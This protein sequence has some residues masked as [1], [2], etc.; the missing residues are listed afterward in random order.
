MKVR[1]LATVAALALLAFSRPTLADN[2]FT[3]NFNGI[4]LPPPAGNGIAPINGFY[5]GKGG[6][7]YGVTFSPSSLAIILDS[8]SNVGPSPGSGDGALSSD[9]SGEIRF[10]LGS[11]LLLNGLSVFFNR[12]LGPTAPTL[13][14]LSNGKVAFEDDLD[15]CTAGTGEGDFCGWTEYKLPQGSLSDPINEVM[16]TIEAAT[17]AFD[18]MTLT[19]TGSEQPIPEPSTFALAA[20]GLVLARRLVARHTR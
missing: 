4:A 13:A 10:K 2:T 1:S 6:P 14:L 11:G 16:I 20:L 19:T 8:T 5:A 15:A 12:Q 7:D 9:E 17:V 18:D 3:M